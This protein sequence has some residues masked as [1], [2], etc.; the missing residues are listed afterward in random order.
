VSKE[1]KEWFNV[2]EIA[3]IL[4][5][6]RPTLY[7]KINT[8]DTVTLQSLQ[9]KEKGITYYSFKIIDM[10]RSGSGSQ[11]NKSESDNSDQSEAAADGDDNNYKERYISH[12]EKEIEDLKQQRDQLNNR[13]AAEQ[14]LHR[15]TQVLFKQQQPQDIKV[16]EAHQ[17]E[18]D[19]KLSEMKENMEKRKEQQDKG[20]FSRLFK[21]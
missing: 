4:G 11:D 21:K 17:R 19:I 1:C 9:R 5:C 16:L 7:K 18:F 14:E 2:S 3:D 8:I 13:L 10:L 6:S 12:L 20:F 15:N